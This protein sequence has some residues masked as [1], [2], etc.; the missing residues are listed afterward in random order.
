L[1]HCCYTAVALLSNCCYT[2]FGAIGRL[3]QTLHQFLELSRMYVFKQMCVFVCV[4]VRVCVS[5]CVGGRVCMCVYVC[6]C[7]CYARM[8]HNLTFSTVAHLFVHTQ[9]CILSHPHLLRLS[10]ALA[11]P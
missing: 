3:H 8:I 9:T 7:V 6:V 4:G 1:L 2:P 5:V 10:A 11:Q